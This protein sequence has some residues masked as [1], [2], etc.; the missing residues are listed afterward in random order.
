MA[1]LL[2][3][4]LRA[5]P[6]HPYSAVQAANGCLL[7]ASPSSL[8]LS[9]VRCF[10]RD[11]GRIEVIL[12]EDIRNL[13][14]KDDIVQVR[15]GYARNILVPRNRAIY[16]T[17]DNRR[18]RNLPPLQ[19]Q[20]PPAA[21]HDFTT[22]TAATTPAASAATNHSRRYLKELTAHLG[23]LRLLFYRQSRTATGAFQGRPIDTL[24]VYRRLITQ[25]KAY[26]L[27]YADLTLPAPITALGS[28]VLEVRVRAVEEGGTGEREEVVRLGVQV[29]RG[30][31]TDEIARQRK[32]DEALEALEEAKSR[33]AGNA[34]DDGADG[35]ASEQKKGSA[36]G[37][38]RAGVSKMRA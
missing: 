13:G 21:L 34:A 22:A 26:Y 14:Y 37:R 19:L 17:N 2:L 9:L 30:N 7:R 28:H 5:P 8:H 29:L 12:N 11:Q 4:S 16:A 35:E 36:K 3:R 18:A 38:E 10:R 25:H 20:R 27:H 33:A 1:S 15:R 31:E 32:V 6:M 23:R 24:A